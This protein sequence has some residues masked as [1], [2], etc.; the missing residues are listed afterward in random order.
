[1]TNWQACLCLQTAHMQSCRLQQKLT[2][3]LHVYGYS[4]EGQSIHQGSYHWCLLSIPSHPKQLGRCFI[5]PFDCSSTCH[6][7]SLS[8]MI[9]LSSSSQGLPC[10]PIMAVPVMACAF[11]A[12]LHMPPV[13]SPF[14]WPC[15]SAICSTHGTDHAADQWSSSSCNMPLPMASASLLL[16]G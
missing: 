4:T 9:L 15:G 11:S 2:A 8:C 6:G 12:L 10:S 5:E 14:F 3:R 1:M 7:P 16:M 13:S